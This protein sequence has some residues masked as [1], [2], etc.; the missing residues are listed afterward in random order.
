MSLRL[1]FDIRLLMLNKQQSHRPLTNSGFRL[2]RGKS[3]KLNL[4]VRQCGPGE[5]PGATNLLE[6]KQGRRGLSRDRN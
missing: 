2:D 1:Y 6:G 5:A 3:N 4:S